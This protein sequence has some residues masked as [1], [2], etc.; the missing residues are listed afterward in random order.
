MGH[1]EQTTDGLS[2]TTSVDEQPCPA[3]VTQLTHT[4]SSTHQPLVTLSMS[5]RAVTDLPEPR[6]TSVVDEPCTAVAVEPPRSTRVVGQ[7]VGK[8]FYRFIT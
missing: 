5:N 6:C 3:S 1:Y 4:A 8:K 2:D 7:L